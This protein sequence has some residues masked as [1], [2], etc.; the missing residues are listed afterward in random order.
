M[1]GYTQGCPLSS[2]VAAS[3]LGAEPLVVLEC[4]VG[5]GSFDQDMPACYFV[6]DLVPDK[7]AACHLVMG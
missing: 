6:T 5:I 1:V 2:H 4:C 3:H 7:Q